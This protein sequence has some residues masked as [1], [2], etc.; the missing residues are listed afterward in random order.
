MSVSSFTV[1]RRA[2]HVP[3]RLPVRLSWNVLGRAKIL[4]LGCSYTRPKEQ[5]FDIAFGC[6]LFLIPCSWYS[7][8]LACSPPRTSPSSP[9]STA[10]V[11]PSPP[12]RPFRPAPPPVLTAQNRLVRHMKLACRQLNMS[13]DSPS[14]SYDVASALLFLQIL[15]NRHCR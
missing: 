7:P 5:P 8:L 10:S 4:F 6:M 1:L 3:A 11:R 14:A 9:L 15:I 12:R 13:P 2:H